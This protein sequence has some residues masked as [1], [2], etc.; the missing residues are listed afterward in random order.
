MNDGRSPPLAP[1]A[2]PPVVAFSRDGSRIAA[3]GEDEALAWS[4]DGK[5]LAFGGE[6]GLAMYR[7][8]NQ[9]REP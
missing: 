7:A 8:P 3:G 5:V 9:P 1:V 4:A 6:A 2:A